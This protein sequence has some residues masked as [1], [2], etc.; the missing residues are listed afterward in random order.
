MDN[1]SQKSLELTN[2]WPTMPIFEIEKHELGRLSA[3]DAE[4][5]IARLLKAE[6]GKFGINPGSVQ[7]TGSTTAPDGGI[8]ISVDTKKKRFNSEFLPKGKTI[9]QVKRSITQ[10]S[11]IK[12]EMQ[13][14]EEKAKNGK[15][16]LSSTIDSLVK[17]GGNYIIV[18]LKDDCTQEALD[19]RVSTM[20]EMAKGVRGVRSFQPRFYDSSRICDWI[21]TQPDVHQWINE[22]LG[23]SALCWRPYGNWSSNGSTHDNS[24]IMAPGISIVIP[25]TASGEVYK[26]LSIEQGL[27]A[28]RKI[29]TSSSKSTRIIG[30]PGVGKTRFIEALF[31]D[32]I[33]EGALNKMHAVYADLED[34]LD[35][36]PSSMVQRI[37]NTGK[38]A[39]LI[40]DNCSSQIHSKI[41]KKISTQSSL[42]KL[43][44]VECDS[45][46]DKPQSTNVVQIKIVDV[47]LSRQLLARRYPG[48]DQLTVNRIVGF[49]GGNLTIS[50]VLA[51]NAERGDPIHNLPDRNLLDRLLYQG[52]THDEKFRSH[53]E[54]LSLV[55]SYSV[56][57]NGSGVNELA[58]I[59]SLVNTGPTE[60]YRS[61]AKLLNRG[62]AQQR[63]KWRSI[64][65]PAIAN[66]LAISALDT[67]P[68]PNLE[69]VFTVS[70]PRLLKS[71]AHRL[72][73]I[74]DHH[75]VKEIAKR[76]FSE[77]GIISNVTQLSDDQID[78]VEFL[79]A[80]SPAAFLNHVTDTINGFN[81]HKITNENISS[82]GSISK[83]IGKIAYFPE[84]FEKCAELLIEIADFENS[85][86]SS[87]PANSILEMFFQPYLSNT[88]AKLIQR[89]SL[90]KKLLE[91]DEKRIFDIGINCLSTSLDGPPWSNAAFIGFG[92][93]ARNHG[94]SPNDADLVEWRNCFLMIVVEGSVSGSQSSKKKYKSTL[95]GK[96][97]SLWKQKEIHESLA[98]SWR[99]IHDDKFWWEG[100]KDVC[101]TI[102]DVC[103][104]GDDISGNEGQRKKFELRKLRELEE[105]LKPK[106]LMSKISALFVV[107]GYENWMAEYFCAK[108]RKNR[109]IDL[110]CIAKDL[111]AMF[112]ES[113]SDVS[114]LTDKLFVS[115]FNDVSFDFGKGLVAG[116]TSY[117]KTWKDLLLA[118]D[119]FYDEGFNIAVFQGFLHELGSTDKDMALECLT[120]AGRQSRLQTKIALLYPPNTF[121]NADFDKW[122]RP[123]MSEENF[124][125][126]HRKILSDEK[127]NLISHDRVASFAEQLLSQKNG[128]SM[129]LQELT[130]RFNR[131]KSEETLL[132]ADLFKVALMAVKKNIL[133]GKDS[134]DYELLYIVEEFLN[135]DAPKSEV[136]DWI[137][138]I[139]KAADK[140]YG[141]SLASFDA[142]KLTAEM[143]T[144]AFLS[145]AFGGLSKD[146]ETRIGFLTFELNNQFYLSDSDIGRV[147]EWCKNHA[148]LDA[149]KKVAECIG[150]VTI[151][152]DRSPAFISERGVKYLKACPNPGDVLDG[153][154][155]IIYTSFGS[156]SFAD[157]MECRM[158][159]FE[160]SPA[161]E[162]SE[163][164]AVA[165]KIVDQ[166]KKHI[167][168]I[169][170]IEKTTYSLMEQR[171]E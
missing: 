38:E 132:P 83:I 55:Y 137:N 18:S 3:E 153:Y 47:E 7:H 27:N 16:K 25:P 90:L 72:G 28:V 36:P 96:F 159:A 101:Q 163:L 82:W 107:R 89:R 80:V 100:W 118:L 66:K 145:E 57:E 126:D 37:L 30:H 92:Y 104:N 95:L 41:R 115:K 15:V 102:H 84:N 127:F 156:G 148:S 106:D 144:E 113:G 141:N 125:Y 9:I 77:N 94:S 10:P 161:F 14:K 46:E 128:S 67:M 142:I 62:I 65:P 44:T 111:G 103:A 124:L 31:D 42:I 135:S 165:K 136:S 21:N 88:H 170:S 13:D 29:V 117:L 150:A 98:D 4:K 114:I 79:A 97:K 129:I 11:K 119:Q 162:N 49:S 120:L 155:G 133:D 143:H 131:M 23:K 32:N 75:I 160:N 1:P 71:F 64:L 140:G 152:T 70:H 60:L 86:T 122:V 40:L 134:C 19:D 166:A 164:L 147:I 157:T 52:N 93:S 58:V 116:T 130:L 63:G 105:Y 6:V 138:T 48:L 167:S 112:A 5:L 69:R 50:L 2:T 158:K 61:S 76:W 33:G 56:E 54:A 168:E 121:M 59:G 22:K 87:N 110:P 34:E 171:F 68:I 108:R 24:L 35:T 53:A 8:D 78:L 139:F 123:N 109:K 74:N 169:R 43:I 146:Q 91:N 81:D 45:K 99:K 17:N 151:I 51:E 12:S 39:I 154:A 26:E 85:T 149:W 73:F 20:K